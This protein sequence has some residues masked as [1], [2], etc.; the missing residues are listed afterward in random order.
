MRKE[1]DPVIADEFV[2]VNLAMRSLSREIRGFG[3]KAETRLLRELGGGKI[4]DGGE[5]DGADAGSAH[6]GPG[7]EEPR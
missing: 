5:R 6:D 2:E 4:T 7:E 3:A 1:N